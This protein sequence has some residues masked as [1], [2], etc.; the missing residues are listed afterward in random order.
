MIK[1]KIKNV[2]AK[3]NQLK[4]IIV[5]INLLIY[6]NIKIN[7]YSYLIAKSKD[8]Y[9]NDTD[10]IS[11]Y[12]KNKVSN[13]EYKSDII[14]SGKNFIDKCLN[15]E[16]SQKFYKS[17]LKPIYSSIIP[18]FNCE[19]TISNA[20]CS[21]I[22]Q[23]FT[24]YEI[25]LVDDFSSDNSSLY[26]KQIQEIDKRIKLIK[27]KR[28]MGSLY[29]RSI[30][31]LI[32]KGEF[33]LPLDNDDMFF[34]Y[35]IFNFIYKYSKDYDFDIVG[36]RA[37]QI[38]SYYDKMENIV[39]LYN[40]KYYPEI[41]IVYQPEL[42][43][44][45]ININGRYRTHDVTIWAKSVKKDIY[46]KATLNLGRKRYSLFV[47]W[48]EDTIINFIIFNYAKSFIFLNKY[49]IIHLDNKSTASYTIPYDIKLFGEIYLADI[50]YEFSK[51]NSDKNYA[52]KS[53]YGLR[54]KFKRNDAMK[55]KTNLLYY[56]SLLNKLLKSQYIS[57]KYK[58]KIR[59]NLKSFLS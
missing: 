2:K 54:N 45:M 25:I 38:G 20:I 44:W 49:G 22:N 31:V 19:K 53:A 48:A 4:L 42:S 41:L 35:D 30:G 11:L 59:I 6:I 29:S 36:F 3:K 5:L 33:I 8:I 1:Y 40:Y 32:S 34:N 52:V 7:N 58:N 27:N 55:N 39:D 17:E 51:N 15:K 13:R 24:N 12:S 23:N 47:S 43:T 18:V 46:K 26:I 37:F 28:N 50:I 57:K 10:K 56:K 21:I 16:Y 9:L 14:I